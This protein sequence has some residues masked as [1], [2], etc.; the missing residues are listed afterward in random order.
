MDTAVACQPSRA[1]GKSGDQWKGMSKLRFN[2][3]MSLDG[4]VA[5]PN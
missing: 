3:S 2:I 1:S 5:G 4:F